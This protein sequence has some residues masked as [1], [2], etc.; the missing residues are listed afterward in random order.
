MPTGA[1]IT[2][3]TN[4]IINADIIN[5]ALDVA[6][7]VGEDDPAGHWLGPDEGDCVEHWL[8]PG[9]G[10]SVS[11][12]LRSADTDAEGSSAAAT[13]L[14]PPTP[15]PPATLLPTDAATLGHVDEQDLSPA[16][17]I[18]PQSSFAP[19]PPFQITKSA[20]WR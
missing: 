18:R 9:E 4:E 10:G 6:T 7:G 12:S 17:T 2:V 14:V 19:L 3:A 15:S 13:P 20:Y 16:A 11:N 1:K 5:A 8:G